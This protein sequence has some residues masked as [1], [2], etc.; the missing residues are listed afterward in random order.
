MK[1]RHKIYLSKK[2]TL[3]FEWFIDSCGTKLIYSSSC[4]LRFKHFRSSNHRLEEIIAYL[5]QVDNE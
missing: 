2:I 1:M 3:I 5:S 4:M